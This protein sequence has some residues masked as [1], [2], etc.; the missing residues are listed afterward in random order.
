MA[1]HD[2]VEIQTGKGHKLA[3]ES[4]KEKQQRWRGDKRHHHNAGL[5]KS[6]ERKS[7]SFP[8]DLYK[9]FEYLYYLFKIRISQE[10]GIA[11]TYQNDTNV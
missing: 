6:G 10:V 3:F 7:L 5:F 9:L 2:E 11:W 1:S 8:Y 4:G